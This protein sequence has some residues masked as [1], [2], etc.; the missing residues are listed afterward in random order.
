LGHRMAVRSPRPTRSRV[1]NIETAAKSRVS[2]P[3]PSLGQS[4][5]AVLAVGLV[6]RVVRYALAYPL[7]GDEAFLA[8]NFLTRDLRG[9]ARP[10]E[11]GQVAPP[12]FLWAEWAVTRSLGS[13]EL[14]LRL[15]P[16]LAGVAA[17]ALFWRFCGAVSTRRVALL[18]VAVLAASLYPA[19][20][21]NEVK[22]Y[23]TDLLVSL[24]LTMSGWAVWRNPGS[25]RPWVALIA[26]GVISV[27]CSYTAVFPVAGVG[28][29]LIAQGVRSKSVGGT[30]R[31]VVFSALSAASWAAM[32]KVFAGSQLRETSWLTGLI[33]WR[34][35]FPPIREPWHLPWWLLNVHAGNMMAYPLGGA[36]FGSTATLLLVVVGA[37]AIWSRPRRR[38]LLWLLLGPLPVAF[39]AAAMGRYPYGTSARVMLYTAPAFCLLAAEGIV[40]LLRASGFAKR[41]P[42]L[43][44]GGLALIPVCCLVGDLRGPALG[45]DEMDI[46]VLVRKLA[47]QA[48][49]GD[50]WI[51]FD[52]STPLPRVP[53]L[54]T[55][56]WVQRVAIF[57]FYVLSLARVPTRWEPDPRTVAPA[58]RGR[59][60][61][62]VHHH[63]SEEFYPETRRLA[64]ETAIRDR[65]GPRR[66][67][68]YPVA[69]KSVIGVDI[70]DRKL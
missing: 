9:L 1:S 3:W 8:I 55:M 12:G 50:E 70:F 39:V 20:H 54:M 38:P 2:I 56:I 35:A 64:Y 36:N 52:G 23:A 15:I 25:L 42:I 5:W 4:T 29:L 17:L 68:L 7:W 24:I 14:A 34:D 6:W 57:R 40:A 33:T 37:I 28:L 26:A 46:P 18:G 44:A 48:E 60:W 30:T 69:R 11:Y 49:P 19:R 32:I 16:F 43:I 22:P 10:L 41:G 31:A 66:S 61:L 53:D 65:L 62:I 58:R 67:L 47:S 13:S 45:R 63:G 51:L 27:W 59:T 21:A